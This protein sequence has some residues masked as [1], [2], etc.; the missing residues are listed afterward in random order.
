MLIFAG[1]EFPAFLCDNSR[2]LNFLNVLLTNTSASYLLMLLTDYLIKEH[3][4]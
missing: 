4:K 2:L 3:K 1:D